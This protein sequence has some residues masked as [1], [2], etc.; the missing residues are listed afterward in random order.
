[1]EETE[2][3][4]AFRDGLLKLEATSS[5]SHAAA[6]TAEIA[7]V[8]GD[9]SPI[10]LSAAGKVSC[11]FSW[12]SGSS[13]ASLLGAGVKLWLDPL[14][15]PLGKVVLRG[16]LAWDRTVAPNLGASTDFFWKKPKMDFWSLL[17]CEPEVDFFSEG[18]LGVDADV[19]ILARPAIVVVQ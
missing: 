17:D 13:N 15:V 8:I 16:A 7:G 14:T 5:P 2:K 18:G 1:M 11:L 12:S 6:P 9:G 10:T 3:V 4:L 19:G